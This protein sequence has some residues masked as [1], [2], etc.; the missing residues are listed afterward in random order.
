MTTDTY[1]SFWLINADEHKQ[2]V[3]IQQK[4]IMNLKRILV[5]LAAAI[6]GSL[7]FPITA[8]ANMVDA[9]LEAYAAN[10]SSTPPLDA[11]CSMGSHAVACFESYGDELWV[12]DKVADGYHVDLY[13]QLHDDHGSRISTGLCHNKQTAKAGWT[14]C[15]GLHDRIPENTTILFRAMVKKSNEKPKWTGGGHGPLTQT[16]TTLG[17]HTYKYGNCSDSSPL[18]H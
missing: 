15:D 9:E 8:Q 18:E 13:Y 6:A 2:F 10:T 16:S 4:G 1:S 17:V 7:L 11:P 12:K 5:V 3:R 14:I